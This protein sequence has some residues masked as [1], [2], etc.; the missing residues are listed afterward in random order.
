MIVPARTRALL[1][2]AVQAP[3][4]PSAAAL[5]VVN[6]AGERV[7]LHLGRPRHAPDAPRW[8]AGTGG[9]WPA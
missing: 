7:T 6:A 4:G 8:T 5:G 2:A 9:T 3:Q 1:D